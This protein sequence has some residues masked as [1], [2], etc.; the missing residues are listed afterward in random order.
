MGWLEK[1]LSE[2]CCPLSVPGLLALLRLGQQVFSSHEVSLEK[3][4][5]SCPCV[6]GGWSLGSCFVV[7]MSGWMGGLP[8]WTLQALLPS[9]P[10][11]L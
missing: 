7:A 8:G 9:L 11:S 4:L 1:S 5:L 10:V 6:M 3:K 2:A